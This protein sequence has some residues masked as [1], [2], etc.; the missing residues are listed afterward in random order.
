MP[1]LKQASGRLWSKVVSMEWPAL[2]SLAL[3]PLSVL[4]LWFYKSLS[5]WLGT[6]LPEWTAILPLLAAVAVAATSAAISLK[7]MGLP[8]H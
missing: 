2:I 8:A 6:N 5:G 3:I 1:T 4:L 7:Q